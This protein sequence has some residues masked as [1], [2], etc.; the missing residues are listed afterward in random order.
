M[1]PLDQPC[2]DG[3]RRHAFMTLREAG[4]AD[5]HDLLPWAGIRSLSRDSGV[6]EGEV[7]QLVRWVRSGC[8]R[9][10]YD[11]RGPDQHVYVR[12]LDGGDV[13][14]ENMTDK[15]HAMASQPRVGRI[16][17]PTVA[18]APE[19]DPVVGPE[20]ETAPTPVVPAST[21]TRGRMPIGRIRMPIVKAVAPEPT[22]SVEP[23]AVSEI[24]VEAVVEVVAA[25]P[26]L[27]GVWYV[28]PCRADG[29][30]WRQPTPA[31]A[32]PT[33]LRGC[34]PRPAEDDGPEPYGPPCPYERHPMGDLRLWGL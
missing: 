2:S 14:Y 12:Y 32:A 29:L 1:T 28:G 17:M 20:P 24:F 13:E 7:L 19:P 4:I 26:D 9:V 30:E 11:H 21:P 15:E 23:I 6:T 22:A 31:R 27:C 33:H 10:V 34:R 18:P 5:H 8:P 25:L 3:T 16:R